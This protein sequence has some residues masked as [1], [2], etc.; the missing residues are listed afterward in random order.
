MEM[1]LFT[2][3]L[4]S[5]QA[6]RQADTNEHNTIPTEEWLE[7]CCN[8]LSIEHLCKVLMNSRNAILCV[9]IWR[10]PKILL[11]R[12]QRISTLQVVGVQLIAIVE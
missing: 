1:P 5:L 3:N 2:L 4:D 12:K 10:D 8:Y 11:V 7:I 6:K 9:H